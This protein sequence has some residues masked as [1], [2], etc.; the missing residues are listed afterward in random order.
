MSSQSSPW[1]LQATQ[2]GGR[3]DTTDPVCLAENEI[4]STLGGVANFT[5][6]F[7]WFAPCYAA[8]QGKQ[9]P[10]RGFTDAEALE[11]WSR[12]FVDGVHEDSWWDQGQSSSEL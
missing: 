7:E 10:A 6:A 12:M 3:R 9:T 4:S 2:L 8:F 11:A 1:A 5:R